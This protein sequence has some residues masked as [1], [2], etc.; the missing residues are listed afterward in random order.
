MALNGTVT[1]PAD[2]RIAGPI[3]SSGSLGDIAIRR[4]GDGRLPGVEVPVGV[5]SI[6][7]VHALTFSE[8]LLVS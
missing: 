2:R 6:R 1:C 8:P 4:S 3:R 7:L 5:N